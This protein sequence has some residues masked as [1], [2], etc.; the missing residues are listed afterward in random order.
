MQQSILIDGPAGKI[1]LILEPPRTDKKSCVAVICHPHPLHGGTMNNKVVVTLARSMQKMGITT[2]RFNYR[3]VG[4]SG[5]SYG[6]VA[7]EYDDFKAVLAW[8]QQQ[9]PGYQLW[10]AGFSFGAFI[11][12]K[13]ATEFVCKQLVTVAPSVENMPYDELVPIDCPWL[14]IQGDNDEVVSAQAVYDFV[15]SVANKPRLETLENCGH[16]FHGRLLDLEN[17]I[18]AL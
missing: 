4:Q 2:V 11:A 8:A 13:G 12:A 14:V 18:V 6:D 3:G 5:G 7:G 1:E 16:F 10:L 17:I 15:D 9:C